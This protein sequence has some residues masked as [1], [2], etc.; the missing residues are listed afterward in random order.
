MEIDDEQIEYRERLRPGRMFL[1]D[2][3]EGR[4]VQDEEI[5]E[6]L[7]NS[8]LLLSGSIKIVFLQKILRKIKLKT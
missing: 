7:A 4:I 8:N 2:F 5:K 1:I 3:D 6:S